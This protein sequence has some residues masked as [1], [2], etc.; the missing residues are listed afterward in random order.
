ML[1]FDKIYK[2]FNSYMQAL[3]DE[4]ITDSKLKDTPI[5]IESIKN[6]V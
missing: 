1:Q 3:K 6:K 2:Y 4:L 5:P